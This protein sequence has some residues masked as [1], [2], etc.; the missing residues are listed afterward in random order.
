[1]GSDTHSR[2]MVSELSCIVGH[3]V[4]VHRE[5]E[6]W[7]VWERLT[8]PVS[9]VCFE[10]KTTEFPRIPYWAFSFQPSVEQEFLNLRTS[11]IFGPDNFFFFFC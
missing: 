6:N 1:M 9:E 4:G 7:S 10:Y 11:D 2:W 8:H 3:R 5:L